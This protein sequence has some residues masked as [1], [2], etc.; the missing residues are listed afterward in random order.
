MGARP[1]LLQGG[2]V[3]PQLLCAIVFAL[4]VG[5]PAIQPA[6]GIEKGLEEVTP[7]REGQKYDLEET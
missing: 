5:L 4:M 3:S 7:R 6:I 1:P 2:E